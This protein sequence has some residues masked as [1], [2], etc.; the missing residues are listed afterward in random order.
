VPC[1]ENTP[2]R[3]EL[4]RSKHREDFDDFTAIPVHDRVRPDHE[5]AKIWTIG[6]LRYVTPRL[7]ALLK[8]IRCGEKA[9][10]DEASIARRVSL[11]ELADRAEVVR[12]L[13]RPANFGHPKIRSRASS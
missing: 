13:K 6:Q 2:D 9:L 1:S 11:D 3:K 4:R 8:L 7:G 10:S 5:L 12:G